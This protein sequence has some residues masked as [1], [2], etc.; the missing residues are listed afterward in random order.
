M[1]SS[2]TLIRTSS[3]HVLDAL[4]KLS[5]I[6]SL[7]QILTTIANFGNNYKLKLVVI[8]KI[9]D[10]V[11]LSSNSNQLAL[12]RYAIPC[13]LKLASQDRAEIRKQTKRLISVLHGTSGQML[14]DAAQ[15]KGISAAARNHIMSIIVQ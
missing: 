3:N 2:N 12:I 8:E 13:A 6:T 15:A 4:F 5:D 10:G 1:L 11:L 7:L 14:I 9:S